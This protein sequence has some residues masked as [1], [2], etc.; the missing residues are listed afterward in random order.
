MARRWEKQLFNCFH[1]DGRRDRRNEA[2][3]FEY[4]HVMYIVGSLA[5]E[6]KLGQ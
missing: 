4:N 5:E 3:D 1:R 2:R 6:L